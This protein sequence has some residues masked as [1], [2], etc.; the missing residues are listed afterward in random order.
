MCSLPVIRLLPTQNQTVVFQKK[1]NNNNC[2]KEHDPIY[3]LY[4][5]VK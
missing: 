5:A 3:S 1:P 2:H 4:G